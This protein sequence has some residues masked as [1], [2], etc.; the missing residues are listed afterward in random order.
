MMIIIIG[1]VICICVVGIAENVSTASY[2]ALGMDISV[3]NLIYIS[4]FNYISSNGK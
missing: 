4:I 1:I 3:S 2:N